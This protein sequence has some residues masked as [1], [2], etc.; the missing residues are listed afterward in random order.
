M[1]NG[2]SSRQVR[3]YFCNKE[4]APNSP[5]VLYTHGH[6]LKNVDHVKDLGVNITSDLRWDKH[7]DI[8]CNKANSA[9][10]FIRHNVNIA[11]DKVKTHAYKCYV[12]PVL[13]FSSTVWDSYTVSPTRTL[14]SVQ[15]RAAHYTLGWYWHTSSA[16][17]MLTQLEWEPLAARRWTARLVMFYKIHNGLIAIRMPLLMKLYPLL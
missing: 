4:E 13:E 16:D 11:N 12:R 1:V 15:R 5:P 8:I 3:G 14:E 10:G 6:Q 17:A 2:V 9:L 7:V